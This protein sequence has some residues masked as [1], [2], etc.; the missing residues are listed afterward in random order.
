MN[1]AA[2]TNKALNAD[3]L[4][5]GYEQLRSDALGAGG[6]LYRGFGF[7]LLVREGLAA[8]A[9]AC[10]ESITASQRPA[11][12]SVLL[13]APPPGDLRAELTMILT[14]MALGEGRI[15]TWVSSQRKK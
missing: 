10:R 2:A 13:Q 11:Q 15:T 7:A 3:A 1:D 5:A 6:G 12:S 14:A 8:W 4:R 9:R